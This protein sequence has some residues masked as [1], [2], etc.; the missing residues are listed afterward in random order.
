MGTLMN[1]SIQ[2][3]RSQDFTV[4]TVPGIS[5]ISLAL[6]VCLEIRVHCTLHQT[7]H[8]LKAPVE[9]NTRER[10]VVFVWLF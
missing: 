10:T 1:L 2:K 8:R 9:K 6:F 7:I 4:A 5:C 3:R